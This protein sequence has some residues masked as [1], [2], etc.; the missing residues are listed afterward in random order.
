[1]LALWAALV[2]AAPP[3]APTAM[4]VVERA[5]AAVACPTRE[6]LEA[7]VAARLARNPFAPSAARTAVVRFDRP[8]PNA[9][10]IARITLVETDGRRGTRKL[11]DASC[12]ALAE[13]VS[14]ALALAIDPMGPMGPMGSMGPGPPPVVPPVATAPPTLRAAE[15][16]LR[17]P[18]RD[19][20]EP[21]PTRRKSPPAAVRWHAGASLLASIGQ[22]P[23]VLLGPGVRAEVAG[24]DWRAALGVA[25]LF[26]PPAEVGVTQVA[27]IRLDVRATGCW[28][29]DR[30]SVCADLA[31]AHWIASAEEGLAKPVRAAREALTLGAHGGFDLTSLARLELGL[32]VPLGARPAFVLDAKAIWRGW[33]LTPSLAFVVVL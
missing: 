30:W 12:A 9:G 21:A 33:P 10:F 32:D 7:L 29:V 15:S 13:S 11:V 27:V 20:P 1:M 6:A 22:A 5:P 24:S 31:Y 3:P 2:L 16:D 8:A 23:T 26:S 19:D 17:R 28:R 18:R 4:L 14:L 25:L